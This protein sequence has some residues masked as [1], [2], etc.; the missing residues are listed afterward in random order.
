MKTFEG[1]YENGVVRFPGPVAIP[2]HAKVKV[3]PQ[4]GT[5]RIGTNSD[6]IYEIL[7]RRYNS[8]HTDTAAR[9]NEH[10]P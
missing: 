9:H 5:G 2:E 3:I 8:G 6:E 7:E 10:Q 1:I 4:T